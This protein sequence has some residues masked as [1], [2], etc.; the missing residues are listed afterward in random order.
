MAG[1]CNTDLMHG[2]FAEALIKLAKKVYDLCY[3]YGTLLPEE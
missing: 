1:K 3:T 2:E